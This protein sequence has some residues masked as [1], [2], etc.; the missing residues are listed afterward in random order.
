MP[1]P[2]PQSR[3][4]PYKKDAPPVDTWLWF[5]PG[6]LGEARDV[7]G[8]PAWFPTARSLHAGAAMIACF[9]AVGPM[10]GLELG[11]LPLAVM[12]TVLLPWQWRTHLAMFR[13]QPLVWFLLAWAVWLAISLSWS[14][15][16]RKGAVQE[17]GTMRFGW[18]MIAMWPALR[19][20]RYLIA[21]LALGFLATNAS[22]VV[23]AIVRAGGWEHLDFG[24][25]GRD[26]NAGWWL[27]PAVCGYMFVG[28]LGLHLP[29]AMLFRGRAAWLARAGILATWLGIFATG[30][31]GAM[32]SG[33]A[34]CALA[35]GHAFL[36]HRRSADARAR[37]RLLRWSAATVTLGAA[38]IIAVSFTDMPPGPRIRE[39][40]REVQRVFTQRDVSTFTGARFPFAIWAWELYTSHPIRGVGAGGYEESVRRMLAERGET[41][42]TPH[43]PPQAHNLY[44]H[45]AA[46]LGSVGLLL[47]LGITVVALRGGFKRPVGPDAFQAPG[48]WDLGPGWALIGMLLT[49]AFDVTYVNS[50]PSALLAILF[51]MCLSPRPREAV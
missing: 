1:S 9:L 11:C 3:T 15:D 47:A 43:I 21:A 17:F 7:E 12:A 28:A 20:R 25:G 27:H 33:A 5:E 26:R 36:V 45:A 49:T 39:G 34:L 14:P 46:T 37:R 19:Y 31:R 6:V 42:R 51:T 10:A 4:L 48:P 2:H 13:S 38:L 44:L 23:L 50:Q 35:L 41:P 24:H 22:Q 29:A 40:V 8:K 18:F 30:T 32:L 16:V